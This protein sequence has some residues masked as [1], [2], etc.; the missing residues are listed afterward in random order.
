MPGFMTSIFTQPKKE[1]VATDSVIP[2]DDTC[3]KVN[4]HIQSNG[5]DKISTLNPP[6][7]KGIYNV[8]RF[9]ETQEILMCTC[10]KQI[11]G[12]KN[13]ILP[14]KVRHSLKT[15]YLLCN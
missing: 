8:L 9:S 12:Y 1:V 6:R 11:M 7:L 10:F 4:N 5:C 15:L 14:R 2:E 3:Q 13:R